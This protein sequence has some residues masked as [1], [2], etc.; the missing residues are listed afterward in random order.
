MKIRI[1]F[2]FFPLPVTEGAYLVVSDQLRHFAAQAAEVELICWREDR[3]S[4]ARKGATGGWPARARCILLDCGRE[5][6]SSRVWRVVGSLFGDLTSPEL[7]HYPPATLRKLAE[8]GPADLA[9]YH[10]SYAYSWLLRPT[11]LPPEGK[12]VVCFHNLESE[13]HPLRR[14]LFAGIHR[15][16][17][18]RLRSHERALGGMVDEL[19]FLSPLD[20]ERL[21]LPRSR[22]VPPTFDPALRTRRKPSPTE[23]VVAGFVGAMRFEPNIESVRW[24]LEQVAPRLARARFRGKLVIVGKSMPRRLQSI[25]ARY[26]FVEYR[27]FVEDLEGFWAELSFLLVPH[28]CG[29]GV[30]T[31]ILESVASGVPVLT[32]SLGA[33]ALSPGARNSPFLLCVDDTTEWVRVLCEETSAQATRRQLDTEPF[34]EALTADSVYKGL[35]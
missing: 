22:V 15:R 6:R 7:F 14:G 31:K 4:I 5:S 17:G 29:S 23:H 12:R 34:C 35:L 3:D 18:R 16:N 19:W 9:I 24:L 27:G 20:A 28:I 1:Y 25:A 33:A 26:P 2:P 8:L 11:A 21:G 13:L 10:Y 30:R 32:N